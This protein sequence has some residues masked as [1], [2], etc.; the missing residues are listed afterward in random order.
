MATL[1]PAKSNCYY[2]AKKN[3][4]NKSHFTNR[5]HSNEEAIENAINYILRTGKR[6]DRKG[7]LWFAGA[8]GCCAYNMTSDDYIKQFKFV[9]KYC[10]GDR[11]IKT[12]VIHE[13]LT[14]S[15]EEAQVLLSNF[16][17]C[18][19]IAD[20]AAHLY[21]AEGF[22]CVY[23]VHYGYHE[24]D[25]NS[26]G[27]PNPVLHIHFVINSVSFLTG[28]IFPT[29]IGSKPYSFDNE[30]FFHIPYLTKNREALI[31]EFLYTNC[32]GMANP[33][34]VENPNK[35]AENAYKLYPRHSA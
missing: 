2:D 28:N 6:V 34:A 5:D 7:D 10:R 16:Y 31:N 19:A 12:K 22:Q 20:Y 14:F 26:F 27:K 18:K 3:S 15:P 4:Y 30:V 33:Y 21:Y 9:Q 35:Y 25:I 29:K 17:L 23:A 32:F 24:E 11:E 8:A 13:I 1:N